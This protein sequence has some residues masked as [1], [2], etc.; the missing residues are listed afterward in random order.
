MEIGSPLQSSWVLQET[1]YDQERV[2]HLDIWS[3]SDSNGISPCVTNTKGARLEPKSVKIFYRL[4]GF[5]TPTICWHLIGPVPVLD[6]H[7]SD[8][9][10]V[11]VYTNCFKICGVRGIKAD[12]NRSF[13][14]PSS[15]QNKSPATKLCKNLRTPHL[16][17]D[18][19]MRV[20]QILVVAQSLSWSQPGRAGRRV[21]RAGSRRALSAQWNVGLRHW[22]TSRAEQRG[23]LHWA[24]QPSHVRLTSSDQ[25]WDTSRVEA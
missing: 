16:F 7:N 17:H 15:F 21:A 13:S 8:L 25:Y 12:S 11:L 23:S 18:V 22:E 6:P 1:K 9:S 24:W 20:S 19:L 4:F 14:Q 10:D 3:L 5:W 2:A